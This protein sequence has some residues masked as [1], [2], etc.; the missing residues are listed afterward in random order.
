M[1]RL[2]CALLGLACLAPSG[3]RPAESKDAVRPVG[4]LVGAVSEKSATLWAYTDPGVRVDVRYATGTE[5]AQTRQLPPVPTPDARIPG[6]AYRVTLDGLQPGT[7]Y[8]YELLR[9]DQAW[10]KG[11]GHFRTAPPAGGARF[12][13]AVT[14]CM[15]MGKPSSSWR[16][17]LSQDPAFHLTLGDTHYA[18]TTDPFV[19]W[20]HHLTYRQVPDFARV[21]RH[22]PTFAM[23]DD[24]DYG[25]NNSDG[26]EPG[27][28]RSL[29]SWRAV[30]GNPPSGTKDTPGAFFRFAWGDVDV[31]VLDNR[32]HRSPDKAPDDETKRFLGDTQFAWLMAGLQ[33]S[34]APFKVVA[35]GSTLWHS[36]NDGWRLY[37]F[38]R[39]RLLDAIGKARIPGVL[40][41]GGDIH[42]SLVWEHPPERSA[43][44]GYPLVEVISSG[45]ANSRALSFATL[46]FDTTKPD[47]EFR[48]RIV[49]GTGLVSDERTWRRSQLTP[50]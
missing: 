36:R 30:W 47:P 9:D 11:S 2:A 10:K 45:I 31:F 21:L 4:P 23:W 7:R 5:P 27:K 25:P 44:L 43:R 17:L 8:R 41:V 32:Y 3:A 26:T 16:L 22:V 28:A 6:C 42:T 29:A 1:K 12:R 48:V 18:D 15:K 13:M 37:T 38:A 49:Q 35:N 19:Q 50:K 46:D 14:S 40:F 33:A 20:Q 39:N 34:K 24:H